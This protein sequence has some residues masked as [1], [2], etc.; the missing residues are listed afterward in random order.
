MDGVIGN[1]KASIVWRDRSQDRSF[2]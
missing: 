1:R 2:D